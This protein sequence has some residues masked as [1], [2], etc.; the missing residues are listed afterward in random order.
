MGFHINATTMPSIF[1]ATCRQILG[2]VMD[3]DCL[4]WLFSLV[5]AKKTQ[6]AQS[7]PHSHSTHTFVALLV[8]TTM[9]MQVTSDVVTL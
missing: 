7:C 1:E 5:L 4:T 3:I 9:L 8:G 6:L 2:Q